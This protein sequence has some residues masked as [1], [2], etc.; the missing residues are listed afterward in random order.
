MLA[1][2][3]ILAGI[4]LLSVGMVAAQDAPSATRALDKT[5]VSAGDSVMATVTVSGAARGVVTETLPDGFTYVSSSLPANQVVPDSNNPQIIRFV[6][7]DS[8]DNPFTYTVTVTQ[9]G[10][11]TGKLTADRMDYA[12]TGDSSVA[13][14]QVAAGPSA[15]RALDTNSVSAG[16]SVTATITVNN[17]PRGVVTETLPTATLR[18]SGSSWLRAAT[19]HSATP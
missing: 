1:V 15:T 6:L 9:A 8:S 18:S 17:A 3:A 7:A 11:I 16:D 2:M 10:D 13:I 14:G 5:T 19:A 4:V 12:V